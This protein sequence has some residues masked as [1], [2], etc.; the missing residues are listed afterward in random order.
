MNN[1]G[2]TNAFSG[3][4]VNAY[5]GALGSAAFG[6]GRRAPR[7]ATARSPRPPARCLRPGIPPIATGNAFQGAATTT[8]TFTAEQTANN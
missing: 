2:A 1:R 5:N 7:A 6:D 4:P 3:S 8:F